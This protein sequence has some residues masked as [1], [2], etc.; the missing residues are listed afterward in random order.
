MALQQAGQPGFTFAAVQWTEPTFNAA[1][2]TGS[3]YTIW[4][5]LGGWN[6]RSRTSWGL[7]Q[8]GV[9][10]LGGNGPN[11]DYAWW[12]ALNQYNSQT[13]PE[14]IITNFKVSPGDDVQAVTYY[15]PSD[16]SVAFQLYNITT[17]QLAQLGP[18]TGIQDQN[19]QPQGTADDYYDGSSA[20][21]I[22]ERPT[23]NNSYVNLRQPGPAGGQAHASV[24]TD[25][26]IGNDNDGDAYP[27]AAFPDWNSITM[28]GD[29]GNV[30]SDPS[31][32]PTD[33]S[34]YPAGWTNTWE[35]C[36]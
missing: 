21:M 4:S 17:N 15:R 2:P 19:G 27:G 18:W 12:E 10:N 28:S 32:F 30:V 1:C 24:F 14:Q 35:N 3:G 20:E 8:T 6:A 16:H 13:L 22:A 36:S 25:S 7:L 34:T 33:P 9:D 23:Y 5:G 26:A 29:T 31:G 11:D